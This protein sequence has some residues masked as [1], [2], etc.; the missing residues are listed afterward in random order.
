M[1]LRLIAI[2]SVAAISLLL[3]GASIA[4]PF[5]AQGDRWIT[6]SHD[7]I[8]SLPSFAIKQTIVQTA[9][10]IKE[11][12]PLGEGMSSTQKTVIE[13]DNAKSLA[14]L[15]SDANGTKL[16]AL[17]R[18]SQ[19]AVKQGDAPWAAPSGALAG[20]KDQLANPFACPLPTKAANSPKWAVV[21]TDVVNGEQ[22]VVISTVGNS[23]VAYAEKKIQEG[24]AAGIPDE[25]KRPKVSV[26]SYVSTHWIRKKDKR[27]LKVVQEAHQTV[28]IPQPNSE[29]LQVDV[30]ATTTADYSQFGSVKI[31]VSQEADRV[32]KAK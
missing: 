6:E 4:T 16:E 17:R 30:T 13:I 8:A 27:R 19:V 3:A 18:G 12:K 25:S 11:G 21:R 9:R 23:A 2:N 29:P 1:N 24:I 22:V 26:I 31:S 15:T 28:S 5:D 10:P 14:H 20:I 32:L 7:A